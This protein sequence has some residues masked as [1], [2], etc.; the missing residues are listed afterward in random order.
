MSFPVYSTSVETRAIKRVVRV[1]QRAKVAQFIA[2]GGVYNCRSIAGSST[3]SQ[4]AWG[5]AIDLFP[6]SGPWV[7]KKFTTTDAELAR[8]ADAVVR[9]TTR[10]T[11]ANRGRKLPVSQVIDH[12]NRRIWTPGEGWHPYTGTTGAHVHVSGKPLFS[13]TPPCA[14]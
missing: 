6:K 1:L 4:H 14:R 8:I 12:D 9:Q 11:I 5:N 3:F 10:R 13:G 7:D 2:S